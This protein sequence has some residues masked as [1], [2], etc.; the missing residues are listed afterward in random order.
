MKVYTLTIVFD[1]DTDEVEYIEETL[2]GEGI[3]EARGS[4]D[5]LKALAED[6]GWDS[7]TTLSLLQGWCEKAEA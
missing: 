5:Y 6:E 2:E 7:S 4:V 3:V 1:E